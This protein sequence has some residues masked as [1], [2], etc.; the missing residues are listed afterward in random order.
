[1][2]TRP[3]LIALQG[4]TKPLPIY[5]YGLSDFEFQSGKRREYLRVRLTVKSTGEVWLSKYSNQSSG[6]ISSVTWADALAE[7]DIGQQI[8]FGDKIKYYPI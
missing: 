7:V 3:Y 8:R 1:M 5:Y 4:G 2:I 6:I